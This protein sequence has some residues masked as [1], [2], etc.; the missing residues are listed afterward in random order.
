M[1]L[2]KKVDTISTDLKLCWWD[3]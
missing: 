3:N 1:Y 2:E